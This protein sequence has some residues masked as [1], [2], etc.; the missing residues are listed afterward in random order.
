MDLGKIREKAGESQKEL[1][2]AVDAKKSEGFKHAA[3]AAMLAARREQERPHRQFAERLIRLSEK[4]RIAYSRRYQPSERDSSPL[5]RVPND[6]GQLYIKIERVHRPT[7]CSG[8]EGTPTGSELVGYRFK[9]YLV[10]P[11][12]MAEDRNKNIVHAGYNLRGQQLFGMYLADE[13]DTHFFQTDIGETSSYLQDQDLFHDRL[14]K[15]AYVIGE[16][17][18]A[19]R[20]QDLNPRP[21]RLVLGGELFTDVP[22]Y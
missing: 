19:L 8:P 13:P 6:D 21:E 9:P 12:L 1:A 4:R 22:V 10:D 20:D 16:L 15:S 5:I 17:Q 3:E 18:Q 7:G 14:N 11:D 2:S